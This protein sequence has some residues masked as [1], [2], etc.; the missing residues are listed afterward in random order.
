[1][2]QQKEIELEVSAA[3]LFESVR[4]FRYAF[5]EAI[6]DIVDNSVDAKASVVRLLIQK[7]RD[8][9]LI[10]DD[11][12]GMTFE[13]L[14]YAAVP[15]KKKIGQH[16]PEGRGKYGIGLKGAG[17]SLADRIT[18]HTKQRGGD[19]SRVSISL[20]E[21]ADW[22]DKK[23]TVPVFYDESK[24]WNEFAP[25]GKVGS[26]IELTGLRKSKVTENAIQGLRIELGIMFFRLIEKSLLSITINDSPITA[27]SPILSDLE[28]GSPGNFYFR[29]PDASITYKSPEGLKGTFKL[30]AAHVGRAMFWSND[31]KKTYRHFLNKSGETNIRDQGLYIIR[32]N[33]LITLGG[34]FGVRSFS[35]HHAP[36]RVILE[37]SSDSDDL[38]GIDHTKTKPDFEEGLRQF[39]YDKYIQEVTL[40]SENLFRNEGTKYQ[41]RM[42]KERASAALKATLEFRPPSADMLMD[43]EEKRN[44]ALPSVAAD[45]ARKEGKMKDEAKE[46]DTFLDLRPDLPW[47]ALWSY[48]FNKNGDIKLLINEKHPGYKALFLE[49]EAGDL[50]KKLGL[51]FYYLAFYEANFSEL[52]QK[53]T[54]KETETLK[55]QFAAFRRY[56]SKQFQDM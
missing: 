10:I 15:W 35:H 32:N 26:I 49:T 50:I 37:Y 2:A 8:R 45:N 47:N 51:F 3:G 54:P 23:R 22:P 42:N 46:T 14:A 34:W 56:V 29:F 41:E 21:I 55:K 40:K 44:A 27:L 39:L 5:H 31:E 1:M 16:D 9:L 13:Q 53:L 43:N 36:C 25:K 6:A 7:D 24:I 48:A 18:I 52:T 19:Y 30:S 17:F 33:R 11:G 20:T 4:G 38:L 28:D 12:E